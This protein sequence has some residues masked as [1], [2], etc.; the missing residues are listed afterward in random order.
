MIRASLLACSFA[1]LTSISIPNL[2]TAQEPELEQPQGRTQW[3]EQLLA[4]NQRVA[5]AQK[6]NAAAL[7]AY[8]S[9]RHRRR[10]RGDAKQAIM[11]ELEFSREEIARSQQNLEKLERAA[12]RAGAPPRWLKFDP[13]EID[14]ATQAPASPEP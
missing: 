8:Q 14:A 3:R 2:G 12:R 5:I 4:A 7:S 9:M 1:L 13:A 6:R 10:P 11:D